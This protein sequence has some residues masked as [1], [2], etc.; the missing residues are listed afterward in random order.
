MLVALVCTAFTGVWADEPFYTLD[1]TGDITTGNNSY[2]NMGRVTLDGLT[3]AFQGNGTMHPWRL[4]GKN[5][6]GK[7]RSVYI[8]TPVKVAVSKI[9]L[10]VGTA[11]DITVNSLKLI[12]TTPSEEDWIDNIIDE[13]AVDFEPN[14]TISFTPTNG[15]NWVPNAYYQFV[16]NVSSSATTNKFVQFSKV[17]IYSDASAQNVTL[18]FPES[19]Y[20]AT[21]GEAFTAPTLTNESGVPVTYTSSVEKV[22]TVDPETGAVKL[23]GPGFT[24]ITATFNGNE[25]YNPA[26]AYYRLK[27]VDPNANDGSAEHP[28]TVAEA[29][30]AID[31][32]EGVTG[33]YAKGI[34]SRVVTP[35]NPAYGNIT[36]CIS[37]DGYMGNELQV[38]RGFS[39]NGEWFTSDYD[40]IEGD[41]VV[42][43]GNLKNFNYTYEFD[44]NNQLVSKVRKP[45]IFSIGEAGYATFY[46][47]YPLTFVGAAPTDPE[48]LPTPVG[49]WTFDDPNNPLAGTG[50]ATLTPANH[51]TE[52]PTWL[53]TRESLEAAGITTIDGGLYLPKGSSLLMNTNNGVET[54]DKYTVMFDICSD[55]MSGYTPL[56]QNSM[57][58]SKDGSLFIKNGQMGLGGSLGYNGDFKAGVWY[59]V[60]LVIDTPNKATLYVDGELLSSCE[61]TSSYNSHWLLQGPGAVFFADEDGEEKAIKVT[62]LR[63]WDVP[64]NAMQV[65]ALGTV[66]GEGEDAPQVITIPETTGAWTF[67]GGTPTGTGVAT[68]TASAGVVANED[69]SV[70]VAEGERLELTTNLP[71]ESLNSYTLMM[72]VK[73]PDVARY[74]AILQT[75]LENVND[76]GLFVHNGQIGINSAGLYY[77]G[78]LEN[79]TWYRIVFVVKD[80]YAEE[81]VD[82]ELIGKSSGPLEKWGIGTGFF[83]FEDE[84][85][86][87]D[88]GVATV[89]NIRFW[90]QALTRTQV[91]MLATVGTDPTVKAYT[92]KINGNYLTLTE[93]GGIIPA[94]TPVILKGAPGNYYYEIGG[95][96]PE[97][98]ENDLKGTYDEI[99]AAGKYV[100]AKPEGKAVGFY[101][102]TSGLIEAC[103]AYL[104]LPEATEIKAFYFGGES[105]G[106]TAVKSIT[107]ALSGN[108][109]AVYDLQGRKVN[110]QL[111]RGIYIVNGKKVLVK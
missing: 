98:G 90:N 31:S 16:F 22:A 95:E 36:Y 28:Y 83:L 53:E 2:V 73:F 64:F 19:Q 51:S 94:D 54:F 85:D 84:D 92:G 56:W 9:D 97:V 93:I 107:P 88:E 58:D 80:L 21:L 11:D 55:D 49:A 6:D 30:F 99:K 59:R 42:V 76:A 10:T 70:T 34:V 67:E 32:K 86:D 74:T 102:A 25:D 14:S 77:H 33:V 78:A 46:Y 71:E 106:P 44:A 27:V 50:T 39:Y 108:D 7:E 101:K 75:D 35:L 52:K 23:V 15:K 29:R 8:E 48:E 62:G 20:T 5:L 3:W 4:G 100:L 109:G 89:K 61:N 43:Y 37:D 12:V 111:K 87:N 47:P 60:V 72:D 65:A 40:I 24:A 18:S 66:A 96:A 81:F 69:G 57:T 68:L 26:S 82:G 79:D 63:F 110:S 13:V 91:A 38:Y 1:T 104:E 41:E 17:E 45:L 103:K 105:E